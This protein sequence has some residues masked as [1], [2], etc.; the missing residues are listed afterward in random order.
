MQVLIIG[1]YGTFGFR[2]AERLSDE[3]ELELVLAGRN[4]DKAT[5][6]C[7]KLSGAANFTPL[8][9][10]RNTIDL[11]V[12]P[13]LIIDASGPF[14]AYKGSPILDYCLTHGIHYADLSDD[15]GFVSAVLD[16]NSRAKT[17]DI[18]A[19][20]GSSTCPV[21][22]AIGLREIETKIGPANE[23]MIGI[24]PS[25]KADLGRNV[26]TA[27]TL[28][29]GQKTVP[30]MRHGKQ[31][32]VAGLTEIQNA[33][34]CVPG[35]TPLPRLPFAVADA[36]DAKVLPHSF[37][38]LTD[39]W[40][41][42]GTRPVWMHRLLVTLSRG[43]AK[44]SLPKL[45]PLAD[46]FHRSRAFF[47]FGEHRGGMIVY[48]KNSSDAASWH[49]VADGDHGP[50][51]PT[52]PA[53]AL[54]RKFLRQA[55]PAPGAYSGDQIVDLKSLAPEF[56]ELD[57]TYG[58][59]Y[60]GA[61]L[62]VYEGVMGDAYLRLSP[63]V[64]DLHGTGSGRVFSG[65][66]KVTR[67]KNPLSH[68]VAAFIGFPKSGENVPVSVTVTP[69]ETGESWTRNFGGRTFT[70]HHSSGT[71]R[72]SRHVTERFGPISIHMAILEES[73]NLRIHTK[74]WSIFGIPLPK[75]LRPG[76]DVYETQDTEGR[77]VFHV[78]LIA[79]LFGRLCKYH[80]WLEPVENAGAK[81]ISPSGSG[82][83]QT[84]A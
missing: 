69:D 67:G 17:A 40:T 3:P 2:I 14:Q 9:L 6:A 28:Y 52:L 63:A 36:P 15:G 32:L 23:V 44:G 53:V 68:I 39:I 51:I 75:V 19:V 46:V 13:D 42:A 5:T 43:V 4:L 61:D 48:A 16:Q 47:R 73:G 41:G 10:D 29:A 74:G 38:N 59:Q 45:G 60:D 12:K 7:S 8:K 50:F 83:P 84:S 71:G 37:I 34:I 54:V 58:M 49:L 24:A 72:W 26:V 82:S 30:T 81:E 80:G 76:G 33:T 11:S 1:G 78:D 27:V 55:P 56:A 57:V 64:Q 35:E 22:S 25:P 70:S 20:S 62:P 66:C 18:V 21:L 79:P 65:L 31:I 77:F